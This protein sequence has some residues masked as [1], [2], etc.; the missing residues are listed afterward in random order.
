VKDEKIKG[1][2]NG[3]RI[4]KNLPHIQWEEN[5]L[6]YPVIR[7]DSNE[8]LP[9]GNTARQTSKQQH[10]DVTK[11]RNLLRISSSLA[12]LRAFPPRVTNPVN[13]TSVLL[14]ISHQNAKL[15]RSSESERKTVNII[16]QS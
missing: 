15:I 2:E 8:L 7:R 10:C 16:A 6:G 4:L 14:Q 13:Y 9:E 3:Y 1:E 12:H 11:R 5:L